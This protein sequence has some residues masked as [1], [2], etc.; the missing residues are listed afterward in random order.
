MFADAT[1]T[2]SRRPA[3]EVKPSLWAAVE[4]I[5]VDGQSASRGPSVVHAAETCQRRHPHRI[6]LEKR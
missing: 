1:V 3:H 5:V 6:R 2:M 4:A